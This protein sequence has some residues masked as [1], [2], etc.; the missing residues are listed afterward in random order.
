[1]CVC[2]RDEQI[3]GGGEQ[4]ILSIFFT[5]FWRIKVFLRTQLEHLI[6]SFYFGA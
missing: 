6:M 3:I 5:R 4:I 2:I 1:M